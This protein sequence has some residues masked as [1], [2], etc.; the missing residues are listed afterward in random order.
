MRGELLPRLAEPEGSVREVRG[1]DE[2]RLFDDD[3]SFDL[4]GRNHEDIDAAVA[5]RFEKPRR[6][7]GVRAHADADDRKLGD[8]ILRAEF[9]RAQDNLVR[10]RIRLSRLERRSTQARSTLASTLAETYR[11]GTPDLATIV[12]SAHGLSDAIDRVEY[13]Q[14]VH[15]RNAN[16]VTA[17]RTALKDSKQQ[18]A[19][20]AT[21]EAKFQ[22]LAAAAAK[23]RR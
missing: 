20:L 3:R 21:Q 5:E 2:Q 4:G 9:L 6:H 23:D 12:I 13:E 14:R 10:E 15:E 1:L 8:A 11:R 7:A 22:S 18:E 17:V 16:A 19:V